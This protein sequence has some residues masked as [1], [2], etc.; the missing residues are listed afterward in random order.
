LTNRE[1][2]ERIVPG[3]QAIV[4][5][6]GLSSLWGRAAAFH[7]AN[8]TATGN[9]L[10]AAQ[11]AGVK[12][13]VFVST[14]SLYFDFT[15]RFDVKE[16]DALAERPVNAYAAS[17]LAAERLLLATGDNSL[18]TII[19]R[20]RAIFG[21]H[22]SA[23]LPRLL[24]VA[25]KGWLPLIDDGKAIID[26]TY[27]DNVADALLAA[28]RSPDNL[29]GSVFNISNGQSISVRDLM[30]TIVELFGLKVRYLSIPFDTALAAAKA[31]ESCALALPGQPEPYLTCY[32]VGVL[33][34]SQTLS[35]ESARQTLR[36]APRV[37]LLE[38]LQRT[39]NWWRANNA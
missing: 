1:A 6:G 19:F 29:N 9:L 14:P 25:G 8:V 16:S 34:R 26:L 30:R 22:D 38:G 10:S 13:F 39:A 32:T 2:V 21:P 23:L 37:S 17:K 24:R 7:A 27:V 31:L 20:P 12:R 35:I 3:H 15:D 28:V 36:Y 4:H 18:E 33:G 11:R 5:C